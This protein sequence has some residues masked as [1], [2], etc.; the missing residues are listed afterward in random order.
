[1]MKHEFERIAKIEVTDEMYRTIEQMYMATELDKY[2]FIKM[3]NLKALAKAKETKIIRIGTNRANC[4][5]WIGYEAELISERIDIATGLTHITVKRITPDKCDAWV[6]VDYNEYQ[7]NVI[8][9][10][11]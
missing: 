3:L 6:T 8:I 5:S 9:K 11:A 2:E 4:G 1:M 7:T 10:E